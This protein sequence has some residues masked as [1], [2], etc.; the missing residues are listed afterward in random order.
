MLGG[1]RGSGRAAV[2]AAGRATATASRAC[3]RAAAGGTWA[4]GHVGTRTC[5]EHGNNANDRESEADAF[6]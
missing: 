5:G 1:R 6:V 4:H 2:A 3:V